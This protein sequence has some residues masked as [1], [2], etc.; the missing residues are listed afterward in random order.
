MEDV[1]GSVAGDAKIDADTIVE[2]QFPNR[3]TS[4]CPKLGERVAHETEIG[5]RCGEFPALFA[6]GPDP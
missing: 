4:G 3:Q 2:L 6:A 5:I 1:F